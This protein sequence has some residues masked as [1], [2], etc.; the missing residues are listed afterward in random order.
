[1]KFLCSFGGIIVPRSGD[2][3]LRHI[4]GDTRVLSVDLSITYSDLMVKFGE[5]CGS[6]MIL[7][8]KFP[9]DDLDALVTIKSDEEL[10]SIIEEYEIAAPDAK[11]RAVLFPI[12]AGKKPP[13]SQP[14]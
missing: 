5:L 3:N 11:V 7:K 10:R 1:L 9:G 2:G 12:T 6:P 13:P 4:G 8:C 14:S